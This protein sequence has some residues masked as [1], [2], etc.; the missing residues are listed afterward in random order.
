VYLMESNLRKLINKSG[1][2][3][4]YGTIERMTQLN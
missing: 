4:V 3:R 2:Q 1:R